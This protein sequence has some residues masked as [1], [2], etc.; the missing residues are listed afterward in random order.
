MFLLHRI[1]AVISIS[2]SKSTVAVNFY[3]PS[4][5][6]LDQIIF[7]GACKH[8]LNSYTKFLFLILFPEKNMGQNMSKLTVRVK[9]SP[10]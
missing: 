5:E 8:T 10:V 7:D 3:Q 9:I 1:S 2:C 6:I 4:V